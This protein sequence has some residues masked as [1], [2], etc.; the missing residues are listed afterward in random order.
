M[1]SNSQV[2]FNFP[3][4]CQLPVLFCCSF[5]LLYLLLLLIYFLVPVSRS[6]HP[7]K[8]DASVGTA[9]S[10]YSL[11]DLRGCFASGSFDLYRSRMHL[12]GISWDTIHLRRSILFARHFVDY[13]MH[14]FGNFIIDIEHGHL[15]ILD[16]LFLTMEIF[17]HAKCLPEAKLN[18]SDQVYF[19]HALVQAGFTELFPVRSYDELR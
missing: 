10:S 11:T 6:Y 8:E 13:A 18:R 9:K 3:I 5:V 7:Y 2:L 17:Q 1:S 4:G 15:I 19:W 14:P 16:V 12:V